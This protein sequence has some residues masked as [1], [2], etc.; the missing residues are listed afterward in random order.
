MSVML[1]DMLMR[2]NMVAT[3]QK[4]FSCFECQKD[5]VAA[6]NLKRHMKVGGGVLHHYGR[7]CMKFVMIMGES[8]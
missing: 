2:M 1:M 7:G 8:S 4:P 6:S 5:F 3:G